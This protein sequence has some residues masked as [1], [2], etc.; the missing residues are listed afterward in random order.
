MRHPL[1]SVIIPTHGRPH[2]LG[3]ALQSAL[4]GMGDD[5]EVIVVP[6]GPDLSWREVLSAYAVDPRVRVEPIAKAQGSA[7]RNHGLSLAGGKYVRFLDDDD[8]L[9]AAG[10]Q[11]QIELI[12]RSGADVVS[13]PIDLL[14]EDGTCF[15]KVEQPATTD[16]IAAAMRGDRLLQI[17]AH[18]FRRDWIRDIRW[19]DSLPFG[20][21]MDWMFK[22]CRDK[23][24]AWEKSLLASGGWRRHTGRR[25]SIGASLH[26]AKQM[27]AEGILGLVARLE[28]DERLTD[29]RRAAAAS[30]LWECVHSALFMSPTYWSQV[31]AAAERLSPGSCPDTAFFRY[32]FTRLSGLTPLQ[33]E[34]LLAPKRLVTYG[35][36][37][38]LLS[39]GLART[40]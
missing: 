22:L 20:Q 9:Y 13:A 7:A 3:L 4:D 19:D 16:F 28:L 24:P 15:R 39:M 31:A 30:G 27:L 1:V 18:M 35:I 40:W 38:A 5:V 10:V 14:R 11:E 34:K 26:R 12:E 29:Q 23:D 37:R 33:W 32:R 2:Y 17:T 6:N 36:Q 21:D 25:T 8:L